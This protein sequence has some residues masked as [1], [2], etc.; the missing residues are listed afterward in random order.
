MSKL[1]IR[2]NLNLCRGV[3]YELPDQ[4][5]REIRGRSARGRH[6][7][8]QLTVF[9]GASTNHIGREYLEAESEEERGRRY[10]AGRRGA[11]SNQWPF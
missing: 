6:R 10:E 8:T 2:L 1:G 5:K 7:N 4:W 3:A 11:R 9:C